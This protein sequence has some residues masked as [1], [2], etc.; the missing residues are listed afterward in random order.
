MSEPSEPSEPSDTTPIADTIPLEDVVAPEP[1]SLNLWPLLTLNDKFRYRR[2]LY[3]GDRERFEQAI[4]TLG[5]Y[6]TVG[7]AVTKLCADTGL[8]PDD[9]DIKEL[10]EIIA[11]AWKS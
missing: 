9:K 1:Q 2:I 4:N 8:S 7:E 3:H 5:T 6:P 11:P 10:A